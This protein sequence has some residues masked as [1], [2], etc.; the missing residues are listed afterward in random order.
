[1]QFKE[2]VLS[3]VIQIKVQWETI[4]LTVSLL[5]AGRDGHKVGEAR[6]V[7]VGEGLHVARTHGQ[8]LIRDTVVTATLAVIPAV[9]NGNIIRVQRSFE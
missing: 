7:V 1:M 2:Y 9:Y 3:S 4:S 6:N 8:T 5:H